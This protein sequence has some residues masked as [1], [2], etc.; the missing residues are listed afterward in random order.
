[1]KKTRYTTLCNLIEALW[2]KRNDEKYYEID[3]KHLPS[4]TSPEAR[5]IATFI[6]E[7]YE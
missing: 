5:K 3:L 2:M 1:M 7:L 6:E 4:I